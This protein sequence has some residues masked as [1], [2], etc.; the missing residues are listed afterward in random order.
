MYLPY[1][2]PTRWH[3]AP[4]PPNT[5]SRYLPPYSLRF[6]CHRRRRAK[7]SVIMILPNLHA[8]VRGLVLARPT[9]SAAAEPTRRHLSRI[10]SPERSIPTG[11]ASIR[12]LQRRFD[13]IMPPSS[14]SS[15][16]SSSVLPTQLASILDEAAK[17]E[18]RSDLSDEGYENVVR[19][20]TS[21]MSST[22]ASYGKK[23]ESGSVYSPEI[24]SVC[25]LSFLPTPSQRN[26]Y[27]HRAQQPKI[28]NARILLTH[29]VFACVRFR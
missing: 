5:Y 21:F 1:V 20:M 24:L 18:D 23:F 10:D 29:C 25:K 16:S 17:S 6:P 14:S 11:R 15:S 9:T 3:S 8:A 27:Y 4:A 26:N 12:D 28:Y 13:D 7:K 22:I 19:E 2:Q